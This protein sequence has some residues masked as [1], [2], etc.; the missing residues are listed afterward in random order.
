MALGCGL[1]LRSGGRILLQVEL[2]GRQSGV[3]SAARHQF[4]VPPHVG[5]AAEMGARG[6]DLA[7]YA[8]TLGVGGQVALCG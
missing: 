3:E 2:H 6:V 8:K 7:P 1:G 4:V 5:D